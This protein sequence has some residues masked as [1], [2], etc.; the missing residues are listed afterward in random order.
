LSV[1]ALANLYDLADLGRLVHPRAA[2]E[3]HPLSAQQKASLLL[4]IVAEL[5]W[6]VARTKATD[7]THNNALFPPSDV[8]VLHVL[9]SHCVEAICGELVYG[10]LKPRLTAL[11]T[12]WRNFDA[13]LVS[14]LVLRGMLERAERYPTALTVQVE[15]RGLLDGEAAVVEAR[16][17]RLLAAGATIVGIP[18]PA[19]ASPPAGCGSFHSFTTPQL[20]WAK[21][22]LAGAAPAASA[23]VSTVAA[24]LP[25]VAGGAAAGAAVVAAEVRAALNSG[26]RLSGGFRAAASA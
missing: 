7:R 5:R 17:A 25:E 20:R 10:T 6:F 15:P 21:L 4:A 13:S 19:A 2:R 11:R 22:N 26:L 24:L 3:L 12:R 18:A 1:P 8:L 14:Q 23:P 16:A 9:A